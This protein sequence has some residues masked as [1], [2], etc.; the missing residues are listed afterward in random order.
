MNKLLIILYCWFKFNFGNCGVADNKI[1]NYYA[2][3]PYI[4]KATDEAV[5]AMQEELDRVNEILI[6]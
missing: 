3:I 1:N 2:G 6:N 5:A 4:N